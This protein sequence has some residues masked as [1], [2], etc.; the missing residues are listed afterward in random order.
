MAQN[1]PV[2]VITIYLCVYGQRWW[3]RRLSTKMQL[4]VT[5]KPFMF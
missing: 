3:G 2:V 4:D 5:Q 1:K